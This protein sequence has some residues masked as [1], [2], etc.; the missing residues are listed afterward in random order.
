MIETSSV[1]WPFPLSSAAQCNK[2]ASFFQS[3]N[4]VMLNAPM[5]FVVRLVRSYLVLLLRTRVKETHLSDIS[6]LTSIEVSTAYLAKYRLL[7]LSCGCRSYNCLMN[8]FL[9]NERVQRIS[10]WNCWWLLFKTEQPREIKAVNTHQFHG[11][12]VP[13]VTRGGDSIFLF[14]I[15]KLWY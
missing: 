7:K 9:K 5:P 11:R 8:L 6:S 3:L 13:F 1:C 15:H 4:R 14:K 12:R 10:A 2:S